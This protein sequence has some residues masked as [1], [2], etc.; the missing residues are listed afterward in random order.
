MTD[1]QK[2]NAKAKRDQEAA[3]EST[4]AAKVAGGYIR[5]GFCGDF[6]ISPDPRGTHECARC[7]RVMLKKG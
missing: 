1:A 7:R 5:C 2:A 3:K 4:H 6:T